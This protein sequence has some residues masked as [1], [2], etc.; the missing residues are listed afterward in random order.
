MYLTSETVFLAGF[1]TTTI[2]FADAISIETLR[3][4]R[5]KRQ[6]SVAAAP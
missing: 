1:R 3:K 2:A 6:W 4:K 5:S